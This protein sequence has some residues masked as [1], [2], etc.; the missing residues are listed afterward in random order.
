[1]VMKLSVGKKIGGGFFIVLVLLAVVGLIGFFGT[2]RV[3]K[4]AREVFDFREHE[5]ESIQMELDHLKWFEKVA[6]GLANPDCKKIEA[7]VDDHKCN[8]GKFLYGEERKHLEAHAPHL[9][10]VFSAIEKPHHDLHHSLVEINAALATGEAAAPLGMEDM[11]MGTAGEG[12]SGDAGGAATGV[13]PAGGGGWERA[14]EIFTKVTVPALNQVREKLQELRQEMAKNV[15]TDQGMLNTASTINTTIAIVGIVALI[16][17]AA[18]AFFIRRDVTAV[19]SRLIGELRENSGQI[20]D[21]STQVSTSSQQLAELASE[22]AASLEETSASMEEMASMTKQNADN[23]Q[24]AARLMYD[25]KMVVGK[26]GDQMEQ[27]A[28]SMNRIKGQ[29][30]E[31]GKIVKTIDEIAFQTNLLALNA[32]VE[33]ARAGEAGAGFAVVADEVRNLAQRAAEAAKNTSALI[34]ETIKNIKEGHELVTHTKGAFQDV[35]TSANKVAE[36]VGEIAEASREQAQGISQI[37]TAVTEMD[38]A[39]QNNAASAEESASAAEE[40]SG[41]ARSLKEMVAELADYTG[42]V[43]GGRLSSENKGKGSSIISAAKKLIPLKAAQKAKSDSRPQPQQP[44]TQAKGTPKKPVKPE[45][46]IPLEDD[47]GSFKDF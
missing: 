24:Q 23:A 2:R 20:T 32:A 8:F 10:S 15:V 1:M 28:G 35:A 44:K 40:L 29:G 7:E 30:E 43:N 14:R 42:M 45:E 12:A 19:L 5:A 47:E 37:N 39:V 13:P 27:M 22:Q 36:L 26:T 25:T 11:A 33:A 18:I 21:A 31:V 4:E 6:V 3:V 46:V 16:L 9:T 41:Q 38:K 17:G 34:E